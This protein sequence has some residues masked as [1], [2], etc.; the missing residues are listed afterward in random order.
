MSDRVRALPRR[1]VAVC[2]LLLLACSGAG[3]SGAA[4][5]VEGPVPMPDPSPVEY[6]VALWDDG[7][8]GETELMIRVNEL[9]DVDSVLVSRTSGY[10]EFDSAA[11]AGARRLRF[12]PAKRGDRRVATWT[13]LPIRFAR[14]STTVIGV[15]EESSGT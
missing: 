9:G 5:E 14:D 6:P 13:R 4:V 10:A 15:K 11:V 1:L 2:C 8:E 7:V 12:T 3:E